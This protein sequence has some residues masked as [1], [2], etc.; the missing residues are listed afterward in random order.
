MNG[1]PPP[2][3][4]QNSGQ[5][6]NPVISDFPQQFL[7]GQREWQKVDSIRWGDADTVHLV[8]PAGGA[9]LP[10]Q[11][12]S[13]QLVATHAPR[14]IAWLLQFNASGTNLVAIGEV[15]AVAMLFRVTLG[16]GQSRTTILV[17]IALTAAGGYLPP[18]PPPQIFIP[19][20]DLQVDVL[21]TMAA[22]TV[23][24]DHQFDVACMCAPWTALP[25]GESSGRDQR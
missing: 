6:Y 3:F 7:E 5:P 18:N 12:Q 2:P 10:A 17:P 1:F 19:A 21:V 13:K 8:V 24:G 11:Q 15:G 25:M 23:L 9:G 4:H 22:P 16:A 14:P 20:G